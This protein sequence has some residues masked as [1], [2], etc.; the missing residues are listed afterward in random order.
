LQL[1]SIKANVSFVKSLYK[2]PLYKVDL[3][4]GYMGF[5]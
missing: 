4:R 2:P 1:A 3:Y 5:I